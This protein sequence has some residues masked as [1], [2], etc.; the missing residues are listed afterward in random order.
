MQLINRLGLEVQK[1]K[2][3]YGS[4][5]YQFLLDST[6]SS[7]HGQSTEAGAIFG[8]QTDLLFILA[9]MLEIGKNGNDRGSII[10]FDQNGA[11]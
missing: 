11:W 1:L 9:V 3:R 2:D 5:S 10:V 6:L 8:E 4:G 7:K